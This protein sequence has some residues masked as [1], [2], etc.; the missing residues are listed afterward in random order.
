M[1]N[2]RLYAK[3]SKC[4]FWLES[5]AFLGH[6]VSKEGIR[7]DPTK[8][9]AI[10]DWHRPTSV[11]E[12]RS[13]VGLA[14]YYRRF[15][16]GFSTIAAPLTRVDVPFVW[17]EEC[18]ASILRLKELLS[19]AHILTLPDEGEGFMVYCDAYGVDLGCLLMQQGRVIAYASG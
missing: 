9:E 2:Q 11:T 10:R 3:F 19:S 18:E 15:V 7:V 1:K 8:I 17:S 4:E 6:V 13:F 12:V 16:E 5:V 14:S